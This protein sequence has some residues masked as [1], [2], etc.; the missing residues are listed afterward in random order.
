MAYDFLFANNATT[1]IAQAISSTATVITVASGEGAL[2]PSPAPGQAFAITLVDAATGLT[3]E[4]CYCTS[5]SGDELTVVRGQ[6]GKNAVAWSAGDT[7]A[8]YI[9]A[10]VF[11]TWLNTAVA[12][13]QYVKQ[14]GQAAFGNNA[15]YLGWRTD[16]TGLGIV[17]DTT[18]EGTIAVTGVGRLAAGGWVEQYYTLASGGNR[19]ISL[20]F[21]A[22]MAGYVHVIG[23]ANF[24]AQNANNTQLAVLVNG[25]ELSADNVNA[26]TA[27]T[28]HSCV[29]VAKGSVTVG[30]F[31]STTATN[32]PNV[33]HTLSYLFVPS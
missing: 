29:A 14:G 8:N 5:R 27:M 21:T 33:G 3:N 25:T 23:S 32:P 1:T 13:N 12:N 6:E 31:L 18:P 9:T 4:I 24:A 26:S 28:N 20:T 10:G 7:C 19:T 16:G 17:I 30:S 22:P 11:A 2:F 15:V